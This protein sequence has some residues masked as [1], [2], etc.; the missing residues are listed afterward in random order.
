MTAREDEPTRTNGD[1]DLRAA[2]GAV[3]S[4]DAAG[5]PSFEAVL[6]RSQRGTDRQLPWLVPAVTGTVAAAAVAIAVIAA[7]RRP[8]PHVPTAVSIEKWTAPTDFLLETPGREL[9]ETMPVIGEVP[10]IG[11][12]DGADESEKRRSVGP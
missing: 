10:T 5:A 4:E 12:L 6:A 3:R 9:L 1:A 2:F 7:A 11:S 8:E